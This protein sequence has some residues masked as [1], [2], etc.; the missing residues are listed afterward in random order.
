MGALRRIA[1]RLP[2]VEEGL[3]CQKAA[4]KAGNKSFF[5]MG[6]ND[7][8]YNTMVKLRDSLAEAKKLAAKD[9]ERYGVGGHDWVSVTFARNESPPPGLFERWIEE[10]YRLLV[11]KKLV[12]LLP[13]N[14]APQTGSA[15]SVGKKRVNTRE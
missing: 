7:T 4:F 10:S 8:S 12:A 6:M 13:E 14:H 15:Q 1:M 2:Q 9:P 11:P 5:F 3:V